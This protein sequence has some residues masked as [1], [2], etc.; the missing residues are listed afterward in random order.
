MIAIVDNKNTATRNEEYEQIL[1]QIRRQACIAFRDQ[2]PELRDELVA[3]TIANT[4]VAFVRLI[5]RGCGDLVY[6]TVLAKYAIKQVCEGR[7]VGGKLNI[8]D[9]SSEH[10]QRRKGITLQSIDRFNQRNNEWLEVVVEDRSASPADV[11]ATRIDFAEWLRTLS[12]KQRR[13]A[14]TLAT[15]ESTGAAAKMTGVSAAR[16][17]QLRREL[18]CLWDVFQGQAEP[19][20]AAAAQSCAK[21]RESRKEGEWRIVDKTRQLQVS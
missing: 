1:P 7:R 21:H 3:E 9:V 5:E 17:S 15:G 4:F 14:T 12:S 11:A 18:R 19:H 16:V 20:D 6:P 10:A 13:M 8:R 2:S